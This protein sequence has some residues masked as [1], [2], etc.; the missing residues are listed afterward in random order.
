MINDTLPTV[1]EVERAIDNPDFSFHLANIADMLEEA[2]E[3]TPA[4][5]YRWLARHGKAPALSAP[6]LSVSLDGDLIYRWVWL[7]GVDEGGCNLPVAAAK[8][9]DE[10]DHMTRLPAG[11]YYAAS[12]AYRQ[13]AVILGRW[14]DDLEKHG[15]V[16]NSV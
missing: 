12:D 13:A 1:L 9:A 14:L 5:G 6:T 4:R 2:G 15:V 11:P 16:E 3:A 10:V 7:P 8:F